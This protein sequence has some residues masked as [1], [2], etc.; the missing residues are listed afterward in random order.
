[1]LR[2]QQMHPDVLPRN[3]LQIERDSNAIGGGR[4]IV[5]VEFHGGMDRAESGWVALRLGNQ[6]L[7]PMHY[8]RLV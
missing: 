1:M 4:A 3:A 8:E 7:D 2:F 6:C 5:V